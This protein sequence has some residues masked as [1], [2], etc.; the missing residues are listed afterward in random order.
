MGEFLMLSVGKLEVGRRC[1]NSS[2]G[3]SVLEDLKEG[4]N[5]TNLK[6]LKEENLAK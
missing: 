3:N 4:R 1:G 6:K 2:K 5:L